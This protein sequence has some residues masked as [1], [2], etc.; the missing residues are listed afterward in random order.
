MKR[1]L[2]IISAITF[3]VVSV[4]VSAGPADACGGP[5]PTTTTVQETTTTDEPTTSTAPPT[6]KATTTTVKTETSS[7]VAEA[8]EA[9]VPDVVVT[10]PT[11]TG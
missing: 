7:T 6:T 10:T 4:V 9:D 1:T 5:C 3:V 11:F 2:K 8:P